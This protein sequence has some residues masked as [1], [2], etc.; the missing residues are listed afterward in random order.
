MAE[1]FYIIAQFGN[2]RDFKM[3][4]GFLLQRH[5]RWVSKEAFVY[6]FMGDTFADD[7]YKY[8]G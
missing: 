7:S 1:Q 8:Y 3:M 6:F 4:C 5:A 2:V